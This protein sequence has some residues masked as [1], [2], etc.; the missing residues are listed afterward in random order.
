MRVHNIVNVH[1]KVPVHITCI[2][3]QKSK[4]KENSKH[5]AL[6]LSNKKFCFNGI[7]LSAKSWFFLLDEEHFINYFNFLLFS[8]INHMHWD[9]HTYI[10]YIMNSHN[11]FFLNLRMMAW[12]CRNIIL[13]YGYFLF[14][15]YIA[16]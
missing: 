12:S 10:H 7:R 14:L 2:N 5:G 11:V 15:K 3:K 8:L 13:F 16:Y 4:I 1:V 9:L 6:E